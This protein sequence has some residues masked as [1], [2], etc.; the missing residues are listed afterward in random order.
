MALKYSA[1]E[2]CGAIK[3]YVLDHVLRQTRHA[4][5]I[6]IDADILAGAPFARL[7]AELDRH[8]LVVTPHILGAPPHPDRFWE[9]PS[10]GDIAFAGP[11]NSVSSDCA[12]PP[13]RRPSSTP[14]ATCRRS[15]APSCR[16]WAA[17]PSRTPSTG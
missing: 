1:L 14:G 5:L 9:R 13:R 7:V 17:R 2:M 12:R 8:E 11:L 16:S 6:Y 15:R 4:K 3:P 10:L